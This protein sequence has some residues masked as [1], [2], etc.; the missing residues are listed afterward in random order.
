MASKWTTCGHCKGDGYCQNKI[1]GF[2]TIFWCIPFPVKTGCASCLISQGINPKEFDAVVVCSVCNGTGY[3]W[4][5]PEG[6]RVPKG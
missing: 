1:K 5:N 3:V 4:L 2:Q 6:P